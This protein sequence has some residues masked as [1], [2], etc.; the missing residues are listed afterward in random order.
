MGLA[1]RSPRGYPLSRSAPWAHVAAKIASKRAA[2]R[3]GI[4]RVFQTRDDRKTAKT[5]PREKIPGASAQE[6]W[7]RPDSEPRPFFC[8]LDAPRPRRYTSPMAEAPKYSEKM[9]AAKL[10]QKTYDQGETLVEPGTVL[11][12]LF[13]VGS[14][15]LSF[16]R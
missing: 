7:P 10:K 6:E 13:I 4:R 2:L 15:V 11:Q 1:A 16:S 9:I 14:G 5:A 3:G 8:L 12:S